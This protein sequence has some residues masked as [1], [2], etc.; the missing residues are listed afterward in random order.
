MAEDNK[1]LKGLFFGFLG[2]TAIG[3]ILALLYAPKSGK[4]L[5]AD[6]RAK[7]DDLLEEA[8]EHIA[9]AKTKASAVITEAKK[10]SDLLVTDA[11]QRAQT[12]IQDADKVLSGVRQKA[13]NIVEEGSRLKDAVKAGVE[14]YKTERS[15]E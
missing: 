7:A 6:L 14:A 8:E 11:T 4:E 15:R 1:L 3:A 12:L 13:T 2:G 9:A 10:R 5:R